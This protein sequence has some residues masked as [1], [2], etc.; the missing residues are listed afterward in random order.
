MSCWQLAVRW[1]FYQASR[2]LD[3]AFLFLR[4]SSHH[5]NHLEHNA[6][7]QPSVADQ[8]F[9]AENNTGNDETERKS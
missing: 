8:S 2:S 3:L 7:T 9:I 1:L 6:N 4:E 5:V